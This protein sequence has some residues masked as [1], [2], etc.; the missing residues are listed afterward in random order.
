MQVVSE[1]V[2]EYENDAFNPGRHGKIV[3]LVY[4]DAVRKGA[5][6]DSYARDLI[7]I[8]KTM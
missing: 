1:L 2:G 7:E 6:D 8:Q 5:V 3:A 4:E